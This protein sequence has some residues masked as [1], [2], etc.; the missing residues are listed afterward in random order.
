MT[1]LFCFFCRGKTA[2]YVNPFSVL[3]RRRP[4][5]YRLATLKLSMYR[6]NLARK[7][8]QSAFILEHLA[9]VKYKRFLNFLGLFLVFILN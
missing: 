2:S 4:H 8:D 1:S 7:L 6:A 5:D 9:D 3:L